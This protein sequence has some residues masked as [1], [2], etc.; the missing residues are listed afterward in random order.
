VPELPPPTRPVTGSPW[1]A[2]PPEGALTAAG[3]AARLGA[4][5]WVEQQ[6]FALLGGWILEIP[7]PDVKL[8]VA[9]HADHAGWRAQRWYELLPTA[10]PGPDALV[11]APAGLASLSDEVATATAGPDRTVE[12]LAVVHRV[13]LPSLA[14]ALDAHRSWASQVSGPAVVR[15]LEIAARDVGQDWVAGERLLQTLL[16]GPTDLETCRTAQ[17]AVE[18][19][20]TVAGGLVGAESAG[21]RPLG[22]GS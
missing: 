13:L 21:R 18:A 20:L 15:A 10:P 17:I 22:G 5:C 16:D 1:G 14:A 6:L 19:A 12:K 3:D 2:V 8:A 7:E 11:V 4:Y 9:E